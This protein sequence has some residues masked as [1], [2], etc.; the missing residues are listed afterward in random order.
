MW[1]RRQT[2]LLYSAI[3]IGKFAAAKL[4]FFDGGSYTSVSVGIGILRFVF[5]EVRATEILFGFRTILPRHEV[6][7]DGIEASAL[8]CE[9]DAPTFGNV[10]LRLSDT[11]WNKFETF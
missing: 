1:I 6:W 3:I 8:P 7:D 4:G 2:F 5:M 11:T 9:L 10:F